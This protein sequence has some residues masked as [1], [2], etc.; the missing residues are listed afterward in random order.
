MRMEPVTRDEL[1]TIAGEVGELSGWD[2]SVVRHERDPVPWDYQDVV[3][4]YLRPGSRVLDIGTGGG[5]QFLKLVPLIGAGTGIDASADMVARARA[6]TP[7]DLAGKVP[8]R[9]W[10]PGGWSFPAPA[11]TWC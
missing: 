7:A 3:G 10:M 11:S 4:R 2:F 5:E 9:S 8:S 6:N 1:R